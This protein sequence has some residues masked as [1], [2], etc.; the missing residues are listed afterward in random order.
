[1]LEKKI[2]TEVCKYARSLGF[3][4]MKQEWPG[5]H[6]APDRLFITPQGKIFMVEFKSAKGKLSGHQARRIRRLKAMNVD[7]Y[8][9]NNIESGKWLMDMYYVH[10]E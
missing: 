3:D 2:E 8:I 7:V 4:A 6:G 1:M 5:T 9:T 10:P